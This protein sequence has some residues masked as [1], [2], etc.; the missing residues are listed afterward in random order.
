MLSEI[1]FIPTSALVNV[2]YDDLVAVYAPQR[3][4]LVLVCN[5]RGGI[6]SK[7]TVDS[8]WKVRGGADVFKGWESQTEEW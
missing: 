7:L 3:M 2:I 1:K 5:P 8:D 6:S 4:R